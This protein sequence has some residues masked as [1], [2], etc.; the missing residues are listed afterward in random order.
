MFISAVMF[1]VSIIR[2]N[3]I[4]AIKKIYIYK[5]YGGKNQEKKLI[6]QIYLK[7][8]MAILIGCW[9]PLV[10]GDTYVTSPEKDS[11]WP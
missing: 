7:K 4:L 9:T 11:H 3:N 5:L 8:Y 2:H 1:Q 10:G 6:I